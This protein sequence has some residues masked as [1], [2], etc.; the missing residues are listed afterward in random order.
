MIT[1]E[2][3]SFPEY[4][5]MTEAEYAATDYAEPDGAIKVAFDA[6]RFPFGI[7]LHVPSQMAESTGRLP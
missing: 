5:E 7:L 4:L 3:L 6:L 1:V 2:S